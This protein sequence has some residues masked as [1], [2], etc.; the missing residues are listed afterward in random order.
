MIA[1]EVGQWAA[2][3]DYDVIKKFTGY[4]RPSNF[5]IFRDSLKAHGLLEK[6]KQFANNSARFQLAAYKEE[7]EANL[8]TPGLSGFQLLDLHDYLGQGTALVGLLDAFWEPKGFVTEEEFKQFCN[9]TVPLARL[10]QRVF[11]SAATLEADVELA[12][13]GAEPIERG[14]A[15]WKIV[16]S[17]FRGEWE[18]RTIPIGKNHSFGKITA[19]LSKVLAPQEYKLVVTVA[20]ESFFSPVSREI[21]PGPKVKKGV[22]YFE[23]EW[24]FWVFPASDPEEFLLRQ[25]Q[26]TVDGGPCQPVRG[27]D[28]LVTTSWDEAEQKL[29]AGG[30]V[31]LVALT[32]DLSW[33][34]PPLDSVPIFWNRLMTPAWSRM[35]GLWVDLKLEETKSK[36]LMAFPTGSHFD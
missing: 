12:H 35:L 21:V 16:G 28:V 5:E 26:S 33:N 13:Y 32:Q 25:S 9:T 7:I 23:N 20:P 24:K 17:R 27:P 18:P 31:V 30:R 8:R 4:L 6:N 29:A 19:D 36:M 10:R 11:T 14:M 15:V 22:T 3:P 2:Y 34:S 1:H